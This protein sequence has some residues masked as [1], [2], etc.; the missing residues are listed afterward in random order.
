MQYTPAQLHIPDGFLNLVVSLTCWA[1]TAV[2]LSMAVSRTN[3][4]LG[5]R[6]VPLMG[7]MAAFI[8]AA[9]MLNFPVAGG[10]SGHL[11]GGALAAIVLGPW[12]AML[13]M[14]SVIGVQALIYQDG[15]LLVMGATLPLLRTRSYNMS[16]SINGLGG[17]N[18]GLWW[19]PSF[20]RLTQIQNPKPEQLFV[21]I[22]VHE[23]GILDA[24]FG[25]PPPGSPWEGIWFDLPANRHSQGCVLSFA[26]GHTERWKWKAPKIFTRPSPNKS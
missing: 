4:S 24:L 9:Q 5:E 10:T 8:F 22:D 6:Q 17:P 20:Q 15:G 25:L 2:V 23:G 26:D 12:A 18:A 19:I 16:Q 13:V 14:T 3:K 1:I 11:L 7:I 21:F